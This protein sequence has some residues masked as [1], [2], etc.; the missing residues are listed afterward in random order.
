M[1]WLQEEK[2]GK[3]AGKHF[4]SRPRML[5]EASQ[6][7]ITKNLKPQIVPYVHPK[8]NTDTVFS[9]AVGRFEDVPAECI[10]RVVGYDQTIL[11]ERPSQVAPHAPAL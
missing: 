1:K 10:A 8:W 6:Y 4:T 5:R 2:A 7:S 3:E 9:C 11:N